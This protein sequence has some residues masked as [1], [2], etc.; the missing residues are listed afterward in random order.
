MQNAFERH[1]NLGKSWI[2]RQ[3]HRRAEAELTAALLIAKTDAERQDVLYHRAY[4]RALTNQPAMASAD[5]QTLAAMED[6]PVEKLKTLAEFID[7]H[8]TEGSSNQM[9]LF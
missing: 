9:S 7:D 6:P 1:L 2:G 8:R 5:Y 4:A 3:E